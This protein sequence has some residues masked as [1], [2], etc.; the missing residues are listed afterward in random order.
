MATVLRPTALAALVLVASALA[1]GQA[2][3]GSPPTVIAL[4][5]TTTSSSQIDVKPKGTVNA[6]DGEISTS[7]LANARAQFGKPK[8]AVVG[9]DKGTVIYTGQHSARMKAVAKL[10]G[11]TLILNGPLQPVTGNAV[12]IAVVGG[13]GIFAGATGTLTILPPSS[14]STAV[15]VYRLTYGPIA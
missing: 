8:G 13:T 10:P 9:S 11:G 3:A 1:A 14:P 2:T 4:V 7:R 12:V 6:G 5:S 15:N